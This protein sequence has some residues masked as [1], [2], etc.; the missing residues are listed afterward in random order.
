MIKSYVVEDLV[1]NNIW[2]KC[3]ALAYQNCQVH[4]SFLSPSLI[5]YSSSCSDISKNK[6]VWDMDKLSLL[7]EDFQFIQDASPVAG[8]G[9]GWE[10]LLD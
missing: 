8:R 3:N 10:I 7:T 1:F 6:A 9:G 5:P 4:I 2:A